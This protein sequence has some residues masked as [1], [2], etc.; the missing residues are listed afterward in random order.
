MIS[1]CTFT[2]KSKS[3]NYVAE[4]KLKKGAIEQCQTFSWQGPLN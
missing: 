4:W 2:F 1:D 3:I